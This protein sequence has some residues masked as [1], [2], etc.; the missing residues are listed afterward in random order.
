MRIAVSKKISDFCMR[1]TLQCR[2]LLDH[3]IREL[4][5]RGD[6]AYSLRANLWPRSAF[7]TEEYVQVN[8]RRFAVDSSLQPD[9]A[10]VRSHEYH[11]NRLFHRSSVRRADK[12]NVIGDRFGCYQVRR[13][14]RCAPFSWRSASSSS[15][16]SLALSGK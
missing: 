13:G 11:R 2:V 7:G 4:R 3:T 9:T 6:S 15:P 14:W 8:S 1:S 10:S 5:G 16:P 12:G